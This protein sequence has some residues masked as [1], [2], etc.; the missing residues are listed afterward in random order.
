MNDFNY[1][2]GKETNAASQQNDGWQNNNTLIQI[3]HSAV[4]HSAKI[5]LVR[6]VKDGLFRNA[7]K[8]NFRKEIVP[9][10][11]FKWIEVRTEAPKTPGLSGF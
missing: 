8:H 5:S 10:A 9:E 1:C 4:H 11:R 6:S 7:A 3:D 2:P